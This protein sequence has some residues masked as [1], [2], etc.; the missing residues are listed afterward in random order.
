MIG[1]YIVSKEDRQRRIGMSYIRRE[2]GY[3]KDHGPCLYYVEINLSEVTEIN[4]NILITSDLY[5]CKMYPRRLGNP[6]TL[7]NWGTY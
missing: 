6:V 7:I 2:R 1:T 5:L 3:A 4:Y